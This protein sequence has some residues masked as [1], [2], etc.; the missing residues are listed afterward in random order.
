M[1]QAQAQQNLTVS[2]VPPIHD[3][4]MLSPFHQFHNQANVA[5]A[6]HQQS[7]PA[8]YGF[9]ALDYATLAA[10]AAAAQNNSAAY[11][12]HPAGETVIY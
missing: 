12:L 5:A 1:A 10:A 11:G 6:V 7:I 2:Q 4:C 9:G 8:G 3:G